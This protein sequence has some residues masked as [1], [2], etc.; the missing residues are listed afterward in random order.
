MATTTANIDSTEALSLTTDSE[1]NEEAQP[2]AEQNE[3]QSYIAFTVER[4]QDSTS[5]IASQD[6]DSGAKNVSDIAL[7]ASDFASWLRAK[8]YRAL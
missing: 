4:N 2:P 6:E 3:I 1:F 8:V 5:E 7:L